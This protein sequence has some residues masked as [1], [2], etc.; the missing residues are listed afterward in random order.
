MAWIVKPTRIEDK[1]FIQIYTKDYKRQQYFE[2]NFA[3]VNHI[4]KLRNEAVSK[5]MASLAA[6][7]DPNEDNPV[8]QGMPKRPKKEL[9]DKLPGIVALDVQ[10]QSGLETIV[11]VVPSWQARGVLQLELTSENMDLL[12][13]IPPA[14]SARPFIPT[15]EQPNV[16]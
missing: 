8:L 1:R 11:N 6:E 10:T 13:E 14:E 15:I 9:I 12:A 4:T 5:G 16:S 3:M 7:E 2:N